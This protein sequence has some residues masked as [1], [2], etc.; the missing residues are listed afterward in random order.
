MMPYVSIKSILESELEETDQG[1]N[2]WPDPSWYGGEYTAGGNG[3][4]CT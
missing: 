3:K 4:A 2:F 1:S